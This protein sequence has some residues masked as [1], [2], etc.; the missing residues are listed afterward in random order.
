LVTI[1]PT[2]KY[3]LD[4]ANNNLKEWQKLMDE[5]RQKG[6]TP[7]KININ[8]RK[9]V[10]N[11][12]CKTITNRKVLYD[13]LSSTKQN[14]NEINENDKKANNN[15]IIIDETKINIKSKEHVSSKSNKS[16]NKTYKNISY[17]NKNNKKSIENNENRKNNKS[18]FI[19]N[20]IE[21]K[22]RYQTINSFNKK[23][24]LKINQNKL[25]DNIK[26]IKKFKI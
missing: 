14:E 11:S 10:N 20:N 15:S 2:L 23:N 3:T 26:D 7:P 25:R 21:I 24:I 17:I 19:N 9:N 6:W 13:D 4:N 18:H 1:F 16:R 12:L 8:K 22:G 5:G